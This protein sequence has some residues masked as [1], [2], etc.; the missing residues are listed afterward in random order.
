MNKYTRWYNN[1]TEQ[2]KVRTIDGYTEKHHIIPRSLGGS[3][4]AD[5][6][7]R[8]TAREHFICHW[9]LTKMH[10]GEARGKMINALYLMQGKNKYQDRYIN[11]KV[12]E[13]LRQDYSQ[14]ISDLNK[15][16]IQPL[17]EKARQ[18]AA[19]TGRK[20]APFSE[21]WRAKMSES[22][23][24]ENNNRYGVTVSK[25]TKQKMRE[26]ALGRKQSEE[27]IRKKIAATQGKKREK[28]LC[29]HCGQMIAVNT[30]PRWHGENCSQARAA[31]K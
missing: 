16:R 22:K 27:T 11:S 6:I 24:G 28:K 31:H 8:L 18:I 9:L 7:V 19:I 23:Q 10:L 1:I 20:R 21:E 26:K 4:D 29:P 30:Y 3:N 25:E 17:E 5:N 12:Y 13:K 15:G 2:A 14:Y